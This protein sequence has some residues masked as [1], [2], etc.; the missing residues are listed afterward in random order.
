MIVIMLLIW[1]VVALVTF[2]LIVRWR[3]RRQNVQGGRQVVAATLTTPPPVAP[4][5]GATAGHA[6][7]FAPRRPNR[8][9]IARWVMVILV[10]FALLEVLAK[11]GILYPAYKKLET[12]FS[13][14]T[15]PPSN[16]RVEKYVPPPVFEITP[17][18]LDLP[19]RY[20]LETDGPVMVKYPDEAPIRF[21]GKGCKEMPAPRW[22]GPKKFW[23]PKNPESGH[24][25]I[26]IYPIGEGG[27]R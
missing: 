8:L 23:D 9:A 6:V 7:T 22:S 1:L 10:G 21:E 16:A 24:I 3:R 12:A 27:C 20:A 25:F 17:V 18:E 5:H 19:Y 4:A 15:L 2:A 14:N 13:S 26:R 11:Y